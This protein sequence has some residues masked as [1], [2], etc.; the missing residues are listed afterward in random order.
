[1]DRSLPKIARLGTSKCRG[2]SQHRR[3]SSTI[4]STVE[5]LA[6][7]LPGWAGMFLWHANRPD[8]RHISMVDYLAVCLVLERLFAQRLCGRIW[9]LEASRHM[10]RWHFRSHRSEF[11]VRHA[12]FNTQLP[13]YLVTR[14][15]KL[16]QRQY[17]STNVYEDWV[18]LADM[19]WTWQHSEAADRPTGY[20]VH[21]SAW[22][23]FRLA[24]H[25][26]LPG[27][28][29][30]EL[31]ADQLEKIF[32]C[33]DLVEGER[34]SFLWLQAYERHY[35][36]QIFNATEQNRGRGRWRT[37][38][39][40]PIAQITFCMDDREESIRRHLEEIDPAIETLGAAGFFGVAIN[41]R[42]LD[43]TSDTRCARSW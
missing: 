1:M 9:Q 4:Y 32:E 24:Q 20:S 13:E 8:N 29:I 19:I 5:R 37:R 39:S 28:V 3:A 10:L 42:G 43:D 40:R 26:A 22:R 30:C 17:A 33:L 38:E 15:Q 31:D 27:C 23:L 7:E 11:F 25:L 34:G 2:D 12:L 21:R 41:W 35:R 14:A 36:E 18:D 16:V 6:L